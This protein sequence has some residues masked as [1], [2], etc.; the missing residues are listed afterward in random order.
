MLKM[1][2]KWR[3]ISS[4]I[5]LNTPGVK[6]RKD[7]VDLMNGRVVDDFYVFEINEWS[8]IV[9]LTEDGKLVLVEQYRHG[10][11]DITLE[12]PAGLIDPGDG[13]PLITAQRELTEETGYSSDQWQSLGKYH[14]GPSKILNSFH[15]FLAKNCKLTHAQNLDDTEDIRVLTVTLEEFERLFEQGKISDVDSSIGWLI[16][17]TKGLFNTDPQ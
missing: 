4:E 6:V 15:L 3:T 12:F 17:Q 11:G 1:T 14:L 9:P 13:S 5:V 10:V 2:K 7:K 16:C 8:T